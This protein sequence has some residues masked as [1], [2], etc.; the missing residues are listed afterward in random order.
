M[1]PPYTVIYA[2]PPW[3]YRD[4]ARAGERG[5]SFKYSV[6]D[7]EAIKA[8]P[9]SGIAAPDSLLFLWSTMPMLPA[10]LEVVEAWGFKYKTVAFVWVKTTVSGRLF[11]GMG[12]WT[13]ANAELILLGIRG[14]PKRLSAGVHQVLMTERRAHSQKPDEARE[15]IVS[16]CGD[17]PRIELFARTKINGWDTW[18]D[19]CPC[20]VE[21]PP[22][23]ADPRRV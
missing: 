17:V 9:V 1:P 3:L 15:R 8:L 12:N 16:L 4:K 19:E 11:W 20:D 6:M 18:G 23:S 22:S 13:R 10:A 14:R 5:A 7:L 2:D 21:F